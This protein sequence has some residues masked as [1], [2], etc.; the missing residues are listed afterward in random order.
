MDKDFLTISEASE[1]LG[2]SERYVLDNITKK[3]LK[4]YKKGKRQ[5][6]FK[7]DLNDFIKTGKVNIE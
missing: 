6:I 4:A 3:K 5:Y 1:L 7:S 2:T